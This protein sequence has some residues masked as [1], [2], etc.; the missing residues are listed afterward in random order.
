MDGNIFWQFSMVRGDSSE[1]TFDEWEYLIC[2]D[3]RKISSFCNLLFLS[4]Y[5]FPRTP[6]FVCVGMIYELTRGRQK[7]ALI[8]AL[9]TSLTSCGAR[10]NG[11]MNPDVYICSIKTDHWWTLWQPGRRTLTRDSKAS[12]NATF[13]S[14]FF[15]DQHIKCP[16]WRARLARKSSTVPVFTSGFQRA[17]IRRAL[18]AGIYFE[19]KYS[20]LLYGRRRW[21]Q[22]A[23][24]CWVEYF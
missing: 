12:K 5:L 8:L 18:C 6:L 22:C 4:M 19:N 10:L 1:V 16:K 7:H 17:K 20:H 14:S 11:D 15:T 13:V 9:Q 23:F 24:V 2:E 3:F 21:K